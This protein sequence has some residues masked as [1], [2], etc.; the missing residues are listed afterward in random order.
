MSATSRCSIKTD[1]TI[2]LVYSPYMAP[3]DLS[4][5]FLWPCVDVPRLC[6]PVSSA[7]VVLRMRQMYNL[8]LEEAFVFLMRKTSGLNC[9]P[10][11]ECCLFEGRE[12]SLRLTL[13]DILGFPSADTISDVASW[14]IRCRC[15]IFSGFSWQFGTN[16]SEMV[17]FK[18]SPLIFFWKKTMT[19][20]VF[21]SR[22]FLIFTS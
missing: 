9:S 12:A 19:T 14:Y 8:L 4:I 15:S 13:T 10:C 21:C 17:K 7:S 3:F 5:A 22:L 1:G 18:R 16:M 11:S 2:T 6:S 20:V